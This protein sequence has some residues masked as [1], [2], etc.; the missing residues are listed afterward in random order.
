MYSGVNET[1]DNW[2]RMQHEVNQKKKRWIYGNRQN[3][4]GWR[5]VQQQK[6]KA[7]S[8]SGQLWS[9]VSWTLLQRMTYDITWRHSGNKH[10]VEQQQQQQSRDH[11]HYVWELCDPCREFDLSTTANLQHT[12]RHQSTS[13]SPPAQHMY[14]CLSFLL[15][16]L[17]VHGFGVSQI[18]YCTCLLWLPYVI[19]QTIIFLPRD[20]YLSFFFFL[21][22]PRLISAAID[23]MST[24][25]PHMVWT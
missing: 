10:S 16:H 11:G 5:T 15:R 9:V 14:V 25:L 6:D 18:S 24:I 23:W 2:W 20:F 17:S 19:G 12:A 22:F 1:R 4:Q 7:A 13:S 3:A 8:D 21:F